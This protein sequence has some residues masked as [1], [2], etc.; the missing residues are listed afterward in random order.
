[1]TAR[2][3]LVLAL[4]LTTALPAVAEVPLTVQTVVARTAPLM[5]TFELSGTIEATENIPVSFR[6]GGRVIGIEVQVG[7]HVTEG[8][9]LARVDPT[10]TEAAA[11]AAEAQLAAAEAS[12]KQAQL[13]HDRAKGLAERGAGTRADLDQA[14]QALLAA[15]SSRDQARAAL[16]KARQAVADTIIHASAS[17][18]VTE[19]TAEPGQVVSAAQAVLTIARDGLREAVFHAPDLPELDGLI[20][21]D[22][23]LRTLDG[24]EQRF[25][26]TVSDI[27]PLADE[28]SG[29]VEVKA[30]LLQEDLQPGLGAAVSSIFELSDAETISLPW[31]ALATLDNKPAVWVVDPD[32]HTV[33]LTPVEVQS[34]TSATIELSG[35]I[36]DGTIVAA[37]GS[38]L[39]YPDRLV[40]PAGDRK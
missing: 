32:T 11:R 9:I 39:L 10:Q 30:R 21:H 1:M 20:G 3:L 12:L 19:R 24:P 8:Q 34:Y 16:A 18:I 4:C 35:G 14:I 28:D 5:V 31:T 26:A 2:P 15:T 7:D 17:G 33:H 38:H 6:N 40:A 22:L 25:P 13:A 23:V 37:S 36:A 29:T 27:S